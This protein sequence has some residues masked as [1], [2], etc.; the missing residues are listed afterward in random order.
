MY[1]EI[2]E[3]LDAPNVF[4]IIDYK[5]ENGIKLTVQEAYLYVRSNR[6]CY[7]CNETDEQE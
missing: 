1:I 5:I 6:E 4:S 2:G 3:I 7:T